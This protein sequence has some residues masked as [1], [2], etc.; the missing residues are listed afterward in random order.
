MPSLGIM[1]PEASQRAA[2]EKHG[3]PDTRSIVNRESL[4]VENESFRVQL[5][6]PLLQ[7]NKNNLCRLSFSDT[8]TRPAMRI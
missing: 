7:L 8:N 3:G 5:F 6:S 1:A 2:L 4:D